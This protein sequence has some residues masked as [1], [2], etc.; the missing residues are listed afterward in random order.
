MY[1]ICYK[2]HTNELDAVEA[3]AK[4]QSEN[5]NSRLLLV[6]SDDTYSFAANI[7]GKGLFKNILV[8]L[9]NIKPILKME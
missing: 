3:V 2:L 7:V 1:N 6:D 8:E 4:C 5:A 9:F